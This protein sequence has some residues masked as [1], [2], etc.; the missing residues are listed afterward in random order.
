MT[1]PSSGVPETP[2]TAVAGTTTGRRRISFPVLLVW[3]TVLWVALWGQITWANVLAG[4]AVAVG[5]VSIVRLP[6][7]HLTSFSVGR[8]RPVRAAVY[9]VYFLSLV[10][11]SNLQLAWQVITPT[12]TVRTGILR[13]TLEHCSDSLVTLIANSFTLTP[14]SIT[15]DIRR[16]PEPTDGAVV[17]VHLISVSDPEVER[18]ALLRLARAAIRAFGTES[19]LVVLEENNS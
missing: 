12:S 3:Y 17:Y 11:R 7:A 4:L 19:A 2:V 1:N 15:I 13:V 14:G 8:I 6:G 16:L 9:A 10:V 18:E 5:V